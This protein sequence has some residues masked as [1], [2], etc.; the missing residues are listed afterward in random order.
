MDLKRVTEWLATAEGFGKAVVAFLGLP[1]LIWAAVT[2]VLDPIGLPRWATFAC[3]ALI[4]SAIGLLLWRSFRR[5]DRASRLEQPDAFTLHP[6]GPASLIGRTEDLGKLLNSVKHNRLVLLDGESGCGKSALVIAG[7]IPQLQQEP[8]G[9]LPVAVRDWGEDWERGPFSAALDALYHSVSPSDREKLGWTSSPD[10]AAD[11]SEL[12]VDLDGRLKAVFSIL[13]RRPL[14]VADQ[15]DDHQAQHR[16]RFLDDEANWLAPAALARRN[17]FWR[18]V[19]TGLVERRLHLL[20]I[21]RADTAAGLASV[22]FLGEDQTVARTLPRVEAEYLRPLLANIAPDDAQPPIVSNPTGGWVELREHIENDLKAEGAILMQQVRTVLLGLRQLPLLTPRRYRVAGGLHGVETL[23]VSRA[24]RRAGDVARGGDMGLRMARA[25]LGKLISP[26]GPNQPP[27]AQRAPLSV[28]SDIAGNRPHA[29]AILGRLQQDEVVRPAEA[30]GD[31]SAWQLDHDYIARAVLAEA[32]QSDR[33][34]VALREGGA[35]YEGA[36]GDW[37]RRRAALL[38]LGTLIRVCWER[39][40]GRLRFGETA[41]YAR[42][43]AIKPTAVILV[44]GLTGV[45]SHLAYRELLALGRTFAIIQDFGTRFELDAVLQVWRAPEPLR[46]RIYSNLTAERSSL[47]RWAKLESALLSNWPLAHAGL[48]PARAREAATALRAQ[49]QQERDPRF[50]SR[51][52]GNYA[53]VADRLSEADVKAEAIVLRARLEQ[54]RDAGIARG[55]AQ[56]YAAVAARLTD[57]ADVKAA[58]NLLRTR[59]EQEGE[60]NAYAMIAARLDG[61]D[62]KAE[63]NILRARLEQER[64]EE[65]ASSLAQAYAAVAARLTEA[66][67]VKAAATVLRRRLEHGGWD[68]YDVR[69]AYATLAARLSEADLKSEATLLRGRLEQERDD[70]IAGNLGEAYAAVA[71]RLTEA[72]DVKAAASL[73][74]ARLDQQLTAGSVLALTP[75]PRSGLESMRNLAFPGHLGQAYATVAA[76]LGE[77]DVT[78]E[79]NILRARLERERD[80]AIARGLAQPYAAVAARL[81]EAADVKAAAT[82]VRACLEREG[83]WGCDGVPEAYA[84]LAARLSE[85]DVKAEATVLRT[86]LEQERDGGNASCLAQAYAAVAGRLTQA[87]DMK[88]AATL[89]RARLEQ[90]LEATFAPASAPLTRSRLERP[91]DSALLG[92]V[93]QAYAIV[94]ARLDA[95]DV[96]SEATTL[97]A[98]LEQERDGRIAA[99]LAVAYAAVAAR[100]AD[101]ADIK[102]AATMVRAR[103]ELES[104]GYIPSQFAQA[105]AQLAGV[106][107]ERADTEGRTALAIEILTLA[108]HPFLSDRVP[109]LA[110]LKPSAKRDFGNDVAAAV[111]W[112]EGTLRIRPSQL[113]PSP[114]LRQDV[115][116]PPSG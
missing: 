80:A 103:L 15:F 34:S 76:R 101:A 7:L 113:R 82:L 90:E 59:L 53:A 43:S 37:K 109:L 10:L 13:G 58:A 95:A 111:T 92:R 57:A 83:G 73:L 87:S 2:K 63:A 21:T 107:F 105:Y 67:D 77:A 26:G 89:L 33:W 47:S 91:P 17:Q 99:G 110:A 96:K 75:L 85:A 78:A 23:V 86:R 12:A 16:H 29:E 70:A 69:K 51:L 4:V 6:T 42:M 65:I 74:R 22:R 115:V 9:L 38:P 27:K 60:G 20:V 104:W 79:A 49:L 48:E 8:G 52:A 66:A 112:A 56:A 55:L 81:T 93:G 25:M 18:V 14:L 5:F 40:R 19:S 35:R 62:V 50:G 97:R 41:H 61:A 46:Q 3:A 24:L 88:A 11:V 114:V 32:R 31:A 36:A 100:L 30:V 44:L 98:R 106:L 39:A 45:A 116:R 84:T 28:L 71:A 108:G 68:A 72:A 54:E 102:A 1:A 64:D 94:A